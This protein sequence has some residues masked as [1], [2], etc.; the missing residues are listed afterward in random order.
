MGQP[1]QCG[2]CGSD[3]IQKLGK[4]NLTLPWRDY[5]AV[6]LTQPGSV[7]SKKYGFN[8]AKALRKLNPQEM[9]PA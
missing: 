7:K 9:Q 4:V 8:M 3:R 2:N 6:L 1:K 5:P